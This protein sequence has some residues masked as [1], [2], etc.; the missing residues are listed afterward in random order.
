MFDPELMK[1]INSGRCF[2]MVGSGPSCELGYPSWKALAEAT[3]DHVL[4]QNPKADKESY[5]ALLAKEDHPALFRQAEIDLGG[6]AALISHTKSL[7]RRGFAPVRYPIYSIL[8]RWPF[9]CYLTTNFDDELQ[10]YLAEAGEHY[11]VVL[12]RPE[13]LSL[14]RDGVSHLVIKVHSDLDHP[15]D[16][17]L[18]SQDYDRILASPSA[19]YLREKLRQVFEMFHV[20]IVGHGMK[21]PDL[22]LILRV[23]KH[24]ASPLHPIYMALTSITSAEIREFREQYNIQVVPYK[25]HD[26]SHSQLR[27]LLGVAD[28]FICSRR[29]A[30][31]SSSP[32]NA[33]QEEAAASLLLF[34]RLRLVAAA[35]PGCV[36]PLVLRVLAGASEPM[37][38]EHILADPSL[39]LLTRSPDFAQAVGTALQALCTSGLATTVEGAYGATPLGREQVAKVAAERRN[40]EEQ[41]LGQFRLTMKRSC[42]TMT[43]EQ[44]RTAEKAVKTALV[45]SFRARGLAMANMTLAGQSLGADD[46]P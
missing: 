43:E 14:L 42:P 15:D 18:T 29:V 33:D 23:A 3:R 32:V 19:E 35:D 1:K 17:V 45:S 36:A 30:V 38:P 16:V 44:G 10:R 27:R 5:A 20:F 24:T 9:A 40:D 28:H 31:P 13:D 7:L 21:D 6:K 12:N 2:A 39:A 41:A 37:P 11:R 34:R 8:A 25:D 22:Q 26:G 46:L 4:G